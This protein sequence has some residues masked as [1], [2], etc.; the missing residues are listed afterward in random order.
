M[1]MGYKILKFTLTTMCAATLLVFD[2]ALAQQKP[3]RAETSSR[4]SLSNI[5]AADAYTFAKDIAGVSSDDKT[6][7][8]LEDAYNKQQG[9][10][11]ASGI[12]A[13]SYVQCGNKPCNLETHICWQISNGSGPGGSGY[14]YSCKLKGEEAPRGIYGMP[15]TP[16]TSGDCSKL[17]DA[18]LGSLGDIEGAMTMNGTDGNKYQVVISGGTISVMYANEGKKNAAIRG[19]EVL[20]VKLYNYKKCFFCPL[21]AVIYNGSA[22]IIDVS[23]TKMA[24]AF[25]TLLALGFAIWVAIQVLSQ[26][27]SL[28]KQ[29]APKF[30]AGIVK[31]SYKILIAFFL[32]QHSTQIFKYAITPILETGLIFGQNMLTY[33]EVFDGIN[34]NTDGSYARQ[35]TNATGGTHLT[36]ETYDK[37]EQ[38]IV[39]VQQNISFMQA[40]GASLTCTGG[41]LMLLKG[42][43]KEFGDG[44]Q[45]FMQGAVLAI[46]GFLLSLAF[47]FYLIDAIVQIGVVGALLPFLI[48]VWPFKV[49]AKYTGT[50]TQML[51]NSAFLL[52]FIGLVVSVNLTL[53]DEAMVQSATDDASE[54]GALYQIAQAL[55]NQESATLKELTDISAIGF[56]ILLFCCIFGFKFTNQ[57]GSLADKFASGTIS[58]PIAPGIATMGAS[59]AKSAA[60]RATEQVRESAG[61]KAE[62][63]VKWGVG[64]APR[65]AKALWRKVRGKDKSTASAS[66]G[67]TPQATANS[68]LPTGEN[69]PTGNTGRSGASLNE[70]NTTSQQQNNMRQNV[71]GRPTLNET[72]NGK[73]SQTPRHGGDA[74]QPSKPENKNNAAN[75]PILSEGQNEVPQNAEQINQS[76]DSQAHKNGQTASSSP[77]GAN[78]RKP[79]DAANA[80]R[81]DD[82]VPHPQG[83]SGHNRRKFFEDKFNEEQMKQENLQN[84]EAYAERPEPQVEQPEP[85]VEQPEPQV[86][87]PEPQVEQP[88]PQVEQPEPQVEEIVP[89]AQEETQT[90]EH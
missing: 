14:S 58:K 55:N 83:G 65:G 1:K 76:E 21:I 36:L 53:I 77:N 33:N 84:E 22:K 48:A 19:C 74:Q 66:G 35:A 67:Q 63:F 87:Q 64:L 88:E 81:N 37:L 72:Q 11:T 73:N 60:L 39:S 20:P 4:K 59:F 40:I 71:S 10:E 90:E 38:F 86:E 15:A 12:P 47:V 34:Y 17:F 85:Q 62:R 27:S 32:L 6:F 41:N 8:A 16:C 42:K 52:L 7:K 26:V 82:T 29:D 54:Y 79:T 25:A 50:G 23:F 30:L 43:I 9:K 51:L 28:T 24:A 49:T 69:I 80:Q 13:G 68:N 46:F 70:R 75:T 57:A 2:V 45:M 18:T 3:T 5:E 31:Q 89:P 44:F 78:P 56:L 61:D